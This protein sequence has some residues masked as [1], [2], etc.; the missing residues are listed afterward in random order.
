MGIE[1]GELRIENYLNHSRYEY[2]LQFGDDRIRQDVTGSGAFCGSVL[3]GR[4]TAVI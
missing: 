4:E 1:N 2:G 3:I